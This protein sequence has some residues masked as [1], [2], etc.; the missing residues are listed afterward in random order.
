MKQE[1]HSNSN[2]KNAFNS[3]RPHNFPW[4]PSTVIIRSIFLTAK[5]LYSPNN[6][7]GCD[8]LLKKQDGG[9]YSSMTRNPPEECLFGRELSTQGRRIHPR[10]GFCR[11]SAELALIQTSKIKMRGNSSERFQFQDKQLQIYYTANANFFKNLNT[12]TSLK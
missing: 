3:C 1:S 2:Q 8:S 9:Y 6:Y 4:N 12:K 7:R 10:R 5:Y 11:E